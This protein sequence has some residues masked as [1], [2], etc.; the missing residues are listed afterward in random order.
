MLSIMKLI[1]LGSGTCVPSLK[2]SSPAY[3]LEQDDTRILIDC[4]SGTL[5]QLVRSG[6]SYKDINAV[7][8]THTHP[9]HIADIPPLIQAL[10]ATPDFIRQKDIF[11]AGP[12]GLR[13]FYD[14]CI[15]SLMMK[16]ETFSVNI[17]EIEHSLDYGPFRI[18]TAATVHSENSIAFRFENEGKSV[19][20]T[21]DAD[22]DSGII[23]L[24][25]NADILI[26]DSAFPETMKRNGHMTS[27]ECGLVAKDADVKKLVLSHLHALP[28]S[29]AEKL[30][31]CR[32]VFSGDVCLAEDFMEFNL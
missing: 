7:F 15:T 23:N 26:A 8:I 11:I 5:M 14:N 27:K 17:K 9:D 13:K 3:Y 31:E 12:A 6:I 25:R 1:I 20:I 4:G 10:I 16:P 29:D 32:D 18:F 22:Y 24:S 30:Y 19:V 21:G 2:R 28:V